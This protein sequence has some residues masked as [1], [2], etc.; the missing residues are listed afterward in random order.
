MF[1][2][3]PCKKSVNLQIIKNKNKIKQPIVFSNILSR[4]TIFKQSSLL[5]LLFNVIDKEELSIGELYYRCL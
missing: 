2:L 4:K 1:S 5:E 3:Q